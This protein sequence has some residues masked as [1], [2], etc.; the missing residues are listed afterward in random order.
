MVNNKTSEAMHFRNELTKKNEDTMVLNQTVSEK[1]K[2]SIYLT[3][4]QQLVNVLL[5]K[6]YFKLNQLLV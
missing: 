1:F 5:G 2:S 4:N 3:R 6:T